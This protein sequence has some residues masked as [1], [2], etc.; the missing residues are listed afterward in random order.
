MATGLEWNTV[1]VYSIP[2]KV[3]EKSKGGVPMLCR[4]P[5]PISLKEGLKEVKRLND[6]GHIVSMQREASES[7]SGA[8]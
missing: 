6:K 5:T 7:P 8:F 3:F 2:K 1:R 4:T